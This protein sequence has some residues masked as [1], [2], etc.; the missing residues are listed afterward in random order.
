[1]S[2][3]HVITTLDRCKSTNKNDMKEKYLT[4]QISILAIFLYS[5]GEMR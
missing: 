3:Y 4:T 1:M 2:F 5:V